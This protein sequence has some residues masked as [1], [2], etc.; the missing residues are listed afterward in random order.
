MR[1]RRPL[2]CLYASS[3]RQ[4]AP[5]L[6]MPSRR[7]AILTPSPMRSP[8]LSSTTSPRWMPTRNSMRRSVGRPALRSSQA[9]LQFDGATDGVN[10]AAKFYDGPV[11]RA[12]D[13]PPAMHGD[14][15]LDQ[16]APQR[17][18]TRQDPIFVS[19]R[20]PREADDV[21]HENR[22]QLALFSHGIRLSAASRPYIGSR[23][24][25]SRICASEKLALGKLCSTLPLNV[26]PGSAN[27]PSHNGRSV[28]VD[29]GSRT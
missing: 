26:S 15:R 29:S 3:D 9:M 23:L 25:L 2:T 18:Q 11:A 7:A 16:I 6:A 20:E 4:I 22:R 13:H 19:A 24:G 27:S 8:S 1:S 10:D 12:L 28:G 14:R 21:R 5:G 17:P